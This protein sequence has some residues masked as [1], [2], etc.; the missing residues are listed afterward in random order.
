MKGLTPGRHWNCPVRLTYLSYLQY[1]CTTYRSERRTVPLNTPS[2]GSG[3]GG[4]GVSIPW[5]KPSENTAA[6][7]NSCFVYLQKVEDLKCAYPYVYVRGIPTSCEVYQSQYGPIIMIINLQTFRHLFSNSQTKYGNQCTQCL[8]VFLLS[9]C[10]KCLCLP[11]VSLSEM[12][13]ASQT[14]K[15]AV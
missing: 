10:Q 6:I 14:N 8:H 2:R 13:G 9:L 11:L 15:E 7:Y 3:G 5:R 1:T 4:E 12:G